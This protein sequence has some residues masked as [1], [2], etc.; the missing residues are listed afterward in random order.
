[1]GVSTATHAK[2]DT[3]PYSTKSHKLSIYNFISL[4]TAPKNEGTLESTKQC[5]KSGT[6]K[7]TGGRGICAA[8]DDWGERDLL[9]KYQEK[10][11]M[12]GVNAREMLR[13]IG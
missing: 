7:V 8:N 3:G 2:N 11:K 10:Q 5:S 13:K 6:S 12:S 1:M 9:E 4:L